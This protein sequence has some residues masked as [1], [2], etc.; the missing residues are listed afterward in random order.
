MAGK[1]AVPLRQRFL[2]EMGNQ[3]VVIAKKKKKITAEKFVH[4]S[5]N[6]DIFV[7]VMMR[8][9]LSPTTQ[10][11]LKK[12]FLVIDCYAIHVAEDGGSV[13]VSIT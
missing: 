13:C 1:V 11:V 4:L 12:K 6:H 5:N 8:R 2:E 9:I 10:F 7:W 3:A